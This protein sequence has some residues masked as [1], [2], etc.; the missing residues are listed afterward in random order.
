VVTAIISAGV[1]ASGDVGVS[2]E[3]MRAAAV[4][5]DIGDV[6]GGHRSG[7][8]YRSAGGGPAG[9]RPAPFRCGDVRGRNRRRVERPERSE[10][11]RR[12]RLVPRPQAQVPEGAGSQP[13]NTTTCTRS[14]ARAVHAAPVRL[15]RICP[16]HR[17]NLRVHGTSSGSAST[18]LR[19]SVRA[20]LGHGRMVGLYQVRRLRRRVRNG[21][22]RPCC[23][24]N[25]WRGHQNAGCVGPLA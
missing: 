8:V 21:G 25:P 20:P 16:P 7:P 13:G 11:E 24:P 18:S 19:K 22:P 9:H 1:A 4:D 23:L 10:G 15:A 17:P 6:E 5:A 2:G 12:G 14:A 3:G